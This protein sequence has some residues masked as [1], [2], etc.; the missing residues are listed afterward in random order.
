MTNVRATKLK[1]PILAVNTNEKRGIQMKNYFYIFLLLVALL[2]G[3]SNATEQQ[4]VL[5]VSAASSLSDVLDEIATQFQEDY[6]NIKVQ[7]NFG[8]SGSLK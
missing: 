3:C 2:T 7:F 5:T 8:V 6:P 4:S 1:C